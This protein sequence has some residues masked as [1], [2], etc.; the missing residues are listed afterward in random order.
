[1]SHVC[2]YLYSIERSR[3]KHKDQELSANTL[4][5]ISCRS[6]FNSC[7]FGSKI[8]LKSHYFTSF[9]NYLNVSWWF[10]S[11]FNL[12]WSKIQC[13]RYM[14]IKDKNHIAKLISIKMDF[15]WHSASVSRRDKIKNTVI[16]QMIVSR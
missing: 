5:F 8:S 15:W 6:K 3:W 13:S 16:K 9:A 12:V 1:M 11:R 2:R 7:N 4:T 10:M 14:S